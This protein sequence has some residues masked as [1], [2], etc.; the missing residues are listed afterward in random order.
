MVRQSYYMDPLYSGNPKRVLFQTVNTQ[1][2]CIS[3]GSTLLVKLKKIFRKNN[4]IFENYNLTP[5]D[6][7]NNPSQVYCI[8][9][10]G[11]LH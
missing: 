7:Y 6:K 3:S 9:P 2:C 4:T 11:L 5:L 8:R 10:E 1:L